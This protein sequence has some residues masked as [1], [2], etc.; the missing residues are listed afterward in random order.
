ME[1]FSGDHVV[2]TGNGGGRALWEKQVD[3][4]MTPPKSSDP[5]FPVGKK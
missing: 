4:T 1:Y 2:F 3:V 5:S